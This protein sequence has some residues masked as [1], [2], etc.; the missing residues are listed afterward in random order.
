MEIT[1]LGP[2]PNLGFDVQKHGQTHRP[3]PKARVAAEMMAVQWLIFGLRHKD[4]D[5]S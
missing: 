2:R 4:Q 3:V 1:P 5:P